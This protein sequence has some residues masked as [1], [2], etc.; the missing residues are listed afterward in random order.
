MHDRRPKEG[1]NGILAVGHREYVGGLWEEIGRLQFDFLVQ[2]GL[3]SSHCLLD[4]ACG[5]LR[6]G[7]HFIPYLERGHYL[8]IDKEPRLIELAIEHELGRAVYEA[9]TPEFV[10]SDRFEFH[11]FSRVP[12]FSI[13]QSLFTHLN[14]ADIRL[15]LEN[16]RRFVERGHVFFAT[17]FEGVSTGNPATSHSHAGFYYSQDQMLRFGQETGWHATYVGD[18]R[19]PRN[20]MLMKYE[21]ES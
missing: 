4:I 7:I 21:A 11:R 18:W 8:G 6:A 15:C 12:Q 19:H 1:N 16:L 3:Q 5:S 14:E 10:V 20:Q 9:K 2:Q 17:F 13:A